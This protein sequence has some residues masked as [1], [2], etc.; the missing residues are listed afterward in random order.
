MTHLEGQRWQGFVMGTKLLGI[1]NRGEQAVGTVS[2]MVKPAS[3][4]C[5]LRCRYC[6]YA[7]VAKNR[8]V[9]S[10][11]VMTDEMAMMLA[12]RIA[13]AVGQTGDA[14]ISFQGGEPTVAG[15]AWFR[16]FVALMEAYPGIT[17]HWSLQTNATLLDAD[18]VAFL[19]EH[20]FLVGVSLD[21][22]Q[23][24]ADY[25]RPDA[26]GA[27]TYDRVMS[28]IELLRA[29]GVGFNVLTVVT[30]QLAQRPKQLMQFYLRHR[31]TD[32]QLIPCLPSLDGADDGFCL[33]P[34]DY[35]DFYLAFF[36]SWRKAAERGRLVRV[37]LFDNL[38]GMLVG[39]PPYQCGMLGRCMVQYVVEANGDVYPCDFYCLDQ[40]RLGNLTEDALLE[41]GRSNIARRFLDEGACRK[42]LCAT[43]SYARICNGG[44][45]RQNVCYL[46]EES[47]AYQEVLAQ[48]LPILAQMYGLR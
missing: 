10:H 38:L 25:L 42:R 20:G 18:W 40:Y 9:A 1:I 14:F 43:C 12:R 41:L 47:C 37:N 27:G 22:P 46:T 19:A 44:C 24:L 3:S 30:R 4:T 39:Q 31:F 11:P 5:N 21:G 28:G 45:R 32:V 7:D 33:R 17:T 34:T 48:V 2:V 23:A 6:F 26:S 13:E 15:L 8:A 35:R 36:R 29:T 16:R